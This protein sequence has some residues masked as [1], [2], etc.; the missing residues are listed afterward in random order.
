MP[1]APGALWRIWLLVLAIAVG[2]KNETLIKL[3]EDLQFRWSAPLKFYH[4]SDEMGAEDA[5]FHRWLGEQAINLR[6]RF[7]ARSDIR[8][9][10][11][12]EGMFGGE[13]NYYD[14]VNW[15][16]QQGFRDPMLL[17]FWRSPPAARLL[18]YFN[19]A[20][21][22]FL[23]ELGDA[24]PPDTN[25]ASAVS[26]PWFAVH[27]KGWFH[28]PHEHLGSICVGV[29]Y[30]KVPANASRIH[31]RDPRT[32]IDIFGTDFEFYPIEG[33]LV[34]FPAWLEHYVEPA[35]EMADNA[36]RVS[37]PINIEASDMR[38]RRMSSTTMRDSLGDTTF[39]A[40]V[41]PRIR[42]E[43]IKEM[44]EEER[45]KIL[46]QIDEIERKRLTTGVFPQDHGI[47]W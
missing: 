20:A 15:N 13:E 35:T 36:T 11:T 46:K 24:I 16:K 6:N 42:A 5:S 37:F 34:M 28:E 39:N 4:I 10:D 44:P 47:I 8:K 32:G 18:D 17:E 29:Y 38:G 1:L 9:Y 41:E 19:A 21:S 33:M 27:T 3:H 25:V 26:E 2:Q 22:D 30:A 45:L 7:L 23:E 12:E 14:F 31:W 43:Y 40:G